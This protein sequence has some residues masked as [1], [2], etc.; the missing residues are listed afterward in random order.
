MVGGVAG[1]AGADVVGEAVCECVGDVG[2]DGSFAVW[3][4]DGYVFALVVGD[5]QDG[6]GFAPGAAVGDGGG[7]VAEFE[8]VDGDGAEDEGALV[9]V[10]DGV[11]VGCAGFVVFGGEAAE[12]HFD[13]GV[14]DGG[15]TESFF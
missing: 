5:F 4:C 8:W 14:D 10:F 11:G 13:G 3:C 9:G 6:V 1:G 12:S 7:D 15:D 2:G